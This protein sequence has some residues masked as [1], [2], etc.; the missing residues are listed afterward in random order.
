MNLE[1][2]Q[3]TLNELYGR[4]FLAVQRDPKLFDTIYH[5]RFVYK[6]RLI[7]EE[8]D[9][10]PALPKEALSRI[11][12]G[13]INGNLPDMTTVA[14]MYASGFA[15]PQDSVKA[16]AWAS[17]AVMQPAQNVTY[18]DAIS[19]LKADHKRCVSRERDGFV[20]PEEFEDT[21]NTVLSKCNSLRPYEGQKLVQGALVTP[22]LAGLRI[23]LVY[24]VYKVEE[25][26][27]AHL[28]GAFLHIGGRI[29]Y[30]LDELR[31]LD[32][33]IEL[34]MH[35]AK[36]VITNY[37]PFGET[38]KL[39]VVQGTLVAPKGLRDD[40]RLHFPETRTVKDLYDQYL[41]SLSRVRI[42]DF[43]F[44]LTDLREKVREIDKRLERYT[45]KPKKFADKIS[46]LQKRK[47]KLEK[48]IENSEAEH[49]R[50]EAEYVKTLPEHYIRFVASGM[51]VYQNDQLMGPQ[52]R[53]K[54]A[55]H[56][57]SLGFSTLNH[58][59]VELV[60]YEVDKD[61]VLSGFDNII[62][63][64]EQAYADQYTVT[65]LTI[66]PGAKS[67]KINRCYSY[68]KLKGE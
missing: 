49:K 7:D 5:M 24:R 41:Q 38:A 2:L 64:F 56:L 14:M 35:G 66:R 28:Y 6:G 47:V 62:A 20:W 58:P 17:F 43:G 40:M 21:I 55:A 26:F 60:G 68:T 11:V 51:F 46:E 10:V 48:R 1:V 19:A 30:A 50:A 8:I 65:G 52:M 15:L 36:K 9:I 22:R 61:G 23:N 59:L 18:V 63:K 53:I 25:Q 45:G 31:Y 54:P 4:N 33:P 13:A 44:V 42:N 57:Q 37:T 39:Y 34:G 29:V 67:V 27:H 12:L 3:A 32:I 16:E